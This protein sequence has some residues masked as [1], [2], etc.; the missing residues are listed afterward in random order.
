MLSQGGL[1]DAAV[2]FY[3]YQGLQ[4]HRSFYCN[5]NFTAKQFGIIEQIWH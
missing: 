4:Q 3:T 5:L 2:N 1:R